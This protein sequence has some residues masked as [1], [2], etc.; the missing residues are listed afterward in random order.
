MTP[1]QCRMARAALRWS[2]KDLAT[3]AGVSPVTVN[4]FEQGRDTYTST[5][6]KLR[7]ALE[8]SGGI[9]FE[10]DCCVCVESSRSPVDSHQG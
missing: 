2:T 5:V 10:G 9:R 8:A 6:S 3:A 1:D 7:T 4:S